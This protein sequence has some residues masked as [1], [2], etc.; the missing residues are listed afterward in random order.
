VCDHE[1]IRAIGLYDLFC[2]MVCRCGECVFWWIV[3]WLICLWCICDYTLLIACVYS[4]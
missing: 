4:S 1:L 2:V 3:K